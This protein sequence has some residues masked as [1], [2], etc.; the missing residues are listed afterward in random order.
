MNTLT[1]LIPNDIHA[2]II[3]CNN[4]MLD[5]YIN[6]LFDNGAYKVTLNGAIAFGAKSTYE[7]W[8]N[9]K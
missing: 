4:E 1:Y 3:T 6:L 9:A 5:M 8:K 2:Y 7:V